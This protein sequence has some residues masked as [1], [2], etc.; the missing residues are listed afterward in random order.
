[1]RSNTILAIAVFASNLFLTNASTYHLTFDSLISSKAYDALGRSGNAAKAATNFISSHIINNNNNNYAT[2]S[3]SQRKIVTISEDVECFPIKIISDYSNQSN[4]VSIIGDKCIFEH[5]YPTYSVEITTLIHT[6]DKKRSNE[7]SQLVFSLDAKVQSASTSLTGEEDDVSAR[8][9]LVGVIPIIENE[10]I[11]SPE[12]TGTNEGN[13]DLVALDVVWQIFERHTPTANIKTNDG[14]KLEDEE[15]EEADDVQSSQACVEK[16]ILNNDEIK[17]KKQISVTPKNEVWEY[18][19]LWTE[20]THRDLFID[21]YLRATTS[22][23]GQAHA[24]AFIH[25]A[26]VSHA[27]PKRVAVISDMPVAYVKEILKYELIE[28]ITLLGA[29]RSSINTVKSFLPQANDCS[30]IQNVSDECMNDSKVKIINDDLSSWLTK[31]VGECKDIDFN[32]TCEYDEEN[33]KYTLC[34]PEPSYDIIF[35]DA[36]SVKNVNEW[37]SL[38]TYTKYTNILTFDSV[39]VI[40]IGSAPTSDGRQSVDALRNIIEVIDESLE[41]DDWDALMVYDEVRVN[42]FQFLHQNDSILKIHI[43]EYDE[44]SRRLNH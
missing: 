11:T 3:G 23:V 44:S 35:I 32:T 27:L 41:C 4:E 20:Q 6:A 16:R 10:I 1:M 29:D 34:A 2:N 28:V 39:I 40:N 30:L 26:M 19:C 17:D 12:T 8:N 42:K 15:E 13:L 31:M 5:R 7:N 18:T 14:I 21:S 38:A 24:E 9:S 33:Q 25:P 36:A 22:P 37:L 43:V